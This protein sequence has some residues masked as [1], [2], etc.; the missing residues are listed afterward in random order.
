M[1]LVFNIGVNIRYSPMVKEEKP[2]M[3]GGAKPKV[4]C[5]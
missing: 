1:I 4:R 3:G 2:K 5:F